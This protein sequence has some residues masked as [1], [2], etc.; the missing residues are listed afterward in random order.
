M[1][2]QLHGRHLRRL[3]D[4]SSD[5]FICR[6]TEQVALPAAARGSECLLTRSATSQLPQG[7]RAYLLSEA[8]DSAAPRDAYLLS[9]KLS[10]LQQG[11][12]IRVDPLRQ[13]ITVL[14]RRTSPFNSLL[15]TERCDNYCVMCSQPP[16]S[17]DD[18]WIIA[19]L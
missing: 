2:M 7:F 16:R 15:V 6:V 5:P 4:V 11:D 14:Y 10:Y 1:L 19:E 9:P 13:F 12:V 8:P 18:G 3:A 17:H